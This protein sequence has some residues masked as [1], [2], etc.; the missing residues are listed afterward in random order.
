MKGNY[1]FCK[2]NILYDLSPHL[3]LPECY[4]NTY[5]AENK[6]RPQQ[7]EG[8]LFRIGIFYYFS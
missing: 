1:L 7:N 2:I 4:Q 6:R 5:F 8:Y 3:N